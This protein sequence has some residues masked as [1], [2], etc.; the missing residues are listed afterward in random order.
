MRLV[1]KNIREIIETRLKFFVDYGHIKM[2][3]I[4]WYIYKY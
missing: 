3:E 1:F 4:E 2:D